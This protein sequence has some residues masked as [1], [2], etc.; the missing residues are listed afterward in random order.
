M[1]AD[2]VELLQD[3]R[4]GVLHL[5]GDGAERR[6]SPS[7]WNAGSCRASGRRAV[8][9]HRFGHDHR[10]PAQE[11]VPADSPEARPG[12]PLIR[13]VR[14]MRAK[15][16]AVAQGMVAQLQGR[17]QAGVLG[18]ESQPEI[19][20]TSRNSSIPQMPAL[21]RAARGLDPAERAHPPRATCRSS[22]P[23][24]TAA[25]GPAGCAARRPATGHSWSGHRAC[26]WR[27][28]PPRPRCRRGSST[29]PGRRFPRARWSCRVSHRQRPWA[30]VEALVHPLGQAKAAGHQPR[31]LVDALLDIALDLVPLALV[32]HRAD[33]LA[34][35]HAPGRP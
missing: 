11:R 15:D 26:H 4:A 7:S 24:P 6:G 2:V 5:V 29:G 32:H 3:H 28:A 8:H 23:C 10:R 16:D 25:A 17:H 21:A 27:C 22:P 9:R 14:G 33:V 13:H 12:H 31:A 34:R 35:P 18:H 1:R 19:A 20:L 30:D